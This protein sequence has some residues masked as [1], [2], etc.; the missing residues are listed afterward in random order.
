MKQAMK[1]LL[2]QNLEMMYEHFKLN[3]NL[4]AMNAFKR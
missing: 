3:K 4:I 1:K 2:M